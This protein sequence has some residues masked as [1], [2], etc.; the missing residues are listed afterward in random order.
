MEARTERQKRERASPSFYK[1]LSEIKKERIS[2]I[3]D[4]KRV[5]QIIKPINL[6]NYDE[7]KHKSSGIYSSTPSNN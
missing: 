1:R 3:K 6:E 4:E 2:K 7:G 5:S